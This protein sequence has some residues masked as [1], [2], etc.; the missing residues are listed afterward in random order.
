MEKNH[1]STPGENHCNTKDNNSC[2]TSK[3]G[4]NKKCF[5]ILIAILLFAAAGM[6][7]GY[8][9]WQKLF[10]ADWQAG[11]DSG[12]FRK[13][14]DPMWQYCGV[15][16]LLHA[17]IFV[18]IFRKYATLTCS[19]CGTKFGR[20]AVFGFYIWLLA[21]VIGGLWWFITEN[22][23][24]NLLYAM[25]VGTGSHYILGGGLVGLFLLHGKEKTSCG[26]K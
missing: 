12:M 26:N 23:S 25:L 5:N 20:G 2:G 4:G 8:L 11:I 3:C 7:T 19:P 6:L 16:Q 24:L 1:C 21:G 13:M 14:D 9:T 15:I 22:V 17:I 18:A 10:I